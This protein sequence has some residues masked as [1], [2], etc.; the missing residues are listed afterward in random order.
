MGPGGGY[1]VHRKNGEF[2]GDERR[3]REK[4]ARGGDGKMDREK[5]GR[6]QR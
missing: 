4:S 5:R 3:E 1:V 6:L 2:V